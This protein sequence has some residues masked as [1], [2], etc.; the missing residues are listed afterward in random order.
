MAAKSHEMARIRIGDFF[1]FSFIF[2]E[3]DRVEGERERER[4][5]VN[6]G[7]KGL[8]VENGIKKT[9]ID[10]IAIVPARKAK[11]RAQL[12]TMRTTVA[13][14]GTKLFFFA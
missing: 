8:Q 13:Y 12:T 3:V 10:L 11:S 9:R 7:A 2:M 1:L 4:E 6:T 14:R 5:R